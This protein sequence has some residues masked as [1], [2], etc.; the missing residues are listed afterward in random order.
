MPTIVSL[1]LG[2]VGAVLALTYWQARSVITRPRM[3]MG[4]SPAGRALPHEAVTLR[5]EDG[6]RLAA[7]YLPGTQPAAV[8]V[9]HGYGME[10]ASMLTTAE[11]LHRA[12]FG[13]LLIDFRAHGASEGDRISFGLHE[14]HDIRA[15]LDYLQQRPDLD[16]R[17][18]GIVGDSMGAATAVLAAAEFPDLAGCWANSPYAAMVDMVESGVRNF[19]SP[20]AVPVA[21]FIRFWAERQGGFRA[22][23]VA[24]LER[25]AAIGPR[26]L[27][28]TAGGR[29]SIVPV[30]ATRALFAAARPPKSLWLDPDA[31][32]C[33]LA[34]R[35]RPAYARA[36][37]AFFRQALL[38]PK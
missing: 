15:G 30:A 6:L 19:V 34:A 35:Q 2:V 23:D 18:I 28:L 33:E 38:A 14:L 24:P 11:Y 16:P 31:E 12:G 26:P 9:Q 3:R 37:V 17:R 7:W 25:V 1:L 36:L 5:T 13:V 29:D 10:K 21:Q 4:I 27:M 32:H 20:S 22:T 8:I